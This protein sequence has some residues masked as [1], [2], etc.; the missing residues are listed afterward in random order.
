MLQNVW[1]KT[2]EMITV[3][4]AF[5]AICKQTPS[6]AA[7]TVKLEKA[8][9]RILAGN[10]VSDIDMPPFNRSA[11]DGFA[12]KGVSD[13]Y[14][15]MDEIPAGIQPPPIAVDGTAAPIMTGA[16]VPFGTDTVVMV[17]VTSVTDDRLKVNK[18]PGRGANICLQAED[19]VKGQI[20]LESGT[21][22]SPSEAGIA[23]MAGRETLKVYRTPSVSVLTTG[24]EVIPPVHI[25]G[26]GQ[27]RNANSVLISSFLSKA[28]YPPVQIFHSADDP[29]SLKNAAEQ[30]LCV[31]DILVTAG[32]VSLGTHDY[33]PSVLEEL[34]FS[35]HFRTV[36]QKPGKPFSFATN[37]ST[38][39]MVFGLPGNPVSVL[40]G[41]EMYLLPCIRLYSG[42][43]K[44]RRKE[45]RGKLADPIQKKPGR[46]NYYRTVA[47]KPK[48]D[49][50]W[51]LTVPETSGSGDL[52]STRGTNSI[53]WLSADSQGAEEGTVVP[54]VLMSWAG[55]ESCWE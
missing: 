24:S 27:V 8:V 30:A 12:I 35:F 2:T 13:V 52:M 31:S 39:K 4:Q 14:K 49:N 9:G 46:L 45:L 15:L 28:G 17:E 10:V 29:A 26:P 51:I 21:L 40:V 11:V 41:L 53:A 47:R 42:H 33:V 36:A 37:S 19:I 16:P 55:G 22:I 48:P 1:R 44:Y 54:F 6:P 5:D 23:A 20:V 38:G 32:G 3:K 43:R 18:M 34:G 7:E 25:P 50:Q